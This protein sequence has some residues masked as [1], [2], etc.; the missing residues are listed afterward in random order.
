MALTL[1]ALFVLVLFGGEDVGWS[2][3]AGPRREI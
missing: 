3:P 2:G 1:L